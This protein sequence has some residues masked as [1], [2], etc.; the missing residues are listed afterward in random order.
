MASAA[1]LGLAGVAQSSTAIFD[2]SVVAIYMDQNTFPS[3]TEYQINLNASTGTT[4][5]GN[6][7]GLPVG[8]TP[9]VNFTGGTIGSP[10]SLDA[11]NGFANIKPVGDTYNLLTI[12][13]PS[14]STYTGAFGDFLFDVQLQ[15][16]KHDLPFNLTI[17]AYNGI[18]SLGTLTLTNTST[19]AVDHDADMS[20]LVLA[21]N[22]NLITSLVLGSTDAGFKETKHFQI[23]DLQLDPNF[24]PGPG[25]QIGDTPLPAALPLF[26]TGL[27]VMGLLGWRRKR[28]AAAIAA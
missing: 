18:T 22:S 15:N 7:Q 12:T 25:G 1:F 6:V 10:Q 26:A 11:A 24:D 20:F 13:V 4:V 8:G 16:P 21:E 3:L 17:T 28:K 5:T 19:P 2:N 27:G 9:V 14:T 23:S